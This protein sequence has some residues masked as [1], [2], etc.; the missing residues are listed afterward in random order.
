[1]AEALTLSGPAGALEALLECP[2]GAEAARAFGVICHPHPLYGGTL[3]NK[4]VHTLARGLH[5]AGIPTLRFNFRGVGASAGKFDDGRGE[6]QDAL[7]A[8][9]Y[10]RERFPG[11]HPWLLGFSFGAVIAI[12]AAAAAGA[13]RLVTVAPAVDRLDP[14][15]SLPRCPW[16]VIQGDA[17]EVVAAAAVLEWVARL[18]RRPAV[19]VLQGAGHF[20]HG[21]LPELRA[22][23]LEF[24]QSR[25]ANEE[26]SA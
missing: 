12:R 4:V 17:D 23:V 6:T 18:E 21:R 22:V 2:A 1:M 9:G 19:R 7:A 5:D 3:Q 24:A 16:L 13:R 8:V 20:F 10:A 25:P 26:G 15:G 14:G 11:A